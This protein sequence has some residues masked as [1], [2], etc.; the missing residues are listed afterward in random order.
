MYTTSTTST[1][2]ALD[3]LLFF[4]LIVFGMSVITIAGMWAAFSKAGKPGWAA[5][6]PI[7]N[8][9]TLLQVGG[10]SGW[11][12]L[13][14]FV[15]F[16]NICVIIYATY[17]VATKFGQGIGTFLLLLIIPVIGYPMIG[18]GSARYQ[19]GQ[20]NAGI[21]GNPYIGNPGGWQA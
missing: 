20:G 14:F 6:I 19:G 1:A 16:L 17:A 8:T 5:I 12:V 13:G 3:A 18:F 11:W 4:Y 10:L 9:V 2:A 15:P 21:T 7:Y